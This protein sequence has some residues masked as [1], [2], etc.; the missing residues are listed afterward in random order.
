[1]PVNIDK[2]TSMPKRLGD[3]LKRNKTH[4]APVAK[5]LGIRIVRQGGGQATLTMTVKKKHLNT[6][7]SVHGGI[8]CDLS[9]AAMGYA[10][11]S[12]LA[13][14]QIGVTVEF[15]INFL[16]PVFVS[17]I[18]KATAEVLSH[19]TTLYYMECAVCNRM[20]RLVAKAAGT[21]KVLVNRSSGG[22][23]RCTP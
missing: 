20:G 5:L 19:G 10:F 6:I 22:T 4:T 16:R 23:V 11:T 13:K 8:L 3:C 21:C 2:R 12:L 18:L 14:D 9:D 1:M 15:K 17:E 7:N